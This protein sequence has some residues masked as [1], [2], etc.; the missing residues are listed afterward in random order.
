MSFCDAIKSKFLQIN[1]TPEKP[2]RFP[3]APAAE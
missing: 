1:L 2:L 3:I